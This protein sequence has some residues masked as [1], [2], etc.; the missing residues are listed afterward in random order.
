MPTASGF[1]L[2]NYVTTINW[3]K[4]KLFHK[5]RRAADANE[6]WKKSS[7]PLQKSKIN[8]LENKNK[9]FNTN[10]N[11]L[12]EN[13]SILSASSKLSVKSMKNYVEL[14]KKPHFGNIDDAESEKNYANPNLLKHSE[15]SIS[16][17]TIDPADGKKDL[18]EN[19]KLQ[20]QK[21]NVNKAMPVTKT[22]KVLKTQSLKNPK[23]NLKKEPLRKNKI[24]ESFQSKDADM[25]ALNK[26]NYVNTKN[27]KNKNFLTN[28]D[29][30]EI[31]YDNESI[32]LNNNIISE[33]RDRNSMWT[34]MKANGVDKENAKKN[35]VAKNFNTNVKSMTKGLKQFKNN[36]LDKKL[37]KTNIVLEIK[38]TKD[39]P[40]ETIDQIQFIKNLRSNSIQSLYNLHSIRDNTEFNFANRS[41][42]DDPSLINHLDS[43]F[44]NVNRRPLHTKNNLK[45]NI[46]V[47]T[48]R[49]YLF[50]NSKETKQLI[51]DQKSLAHDS[52]DSLVFTETSSLSDN[53]NDKIKEKSSR[54]KKIAKKKKQEIFDRTKTPSSESSDDSADGDHLKID[55]K[56]DLKFFIKP[57]QVNTVKET[58]EN[59]EDDEIDEDKLRELVS[60]LIKSKKKKENPNLPPAVAKTQVKN[61]KTVKTEQT[62]GDKGYTIYLDKSGTGGGLGDNALP[63]IS[64]LLNQSK[65]INQ[66]M[67]STFY[68][69]DD[70]ELNY[71]NNLKN[72]NNINNLSN[73]GYNKN[74]GFIENNRNNQIKNKNQNIPLNNYGNNR[75][76]VQS[77]QTI[78]IPVNESLKTTVN[79]GW[80]QTSFADYSQRNNN[81]TFQQRHNIAEQSKYKTNNNFNDI[82][83]NRVIIDETRLIKNS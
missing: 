2:G 51:S 15:L 22:K 75:V 14:K 3:G 78:P 81:E 57:R 37:D 53:E 10:I 43:N 38:S 83:N 12:N 1:G 23:E 31:E 34:N 62:T 33:R 49:N 80:N 72:V 25:E 17:E 27:I 65:N 47:K 70:S 48:Q 52:D 40:V 18:K 39:H 29:A 6:T 68:T 11:D 32:Q 44:V 30:L 54:N 45:E 28:F 77:N 16:S 13:E 56:G 9:N 61:K 82:F 69:A 46:G 67:A 20:A 35:S 79:E 24:R 5:R 66:N 55:Q 60:K 64:S 41:Y 63:N 73:R 4:S 8:N 59:I 50:T 26:V 7:N 21:K 36:S 19:D 76:D 74:N 58:T 42:I 71:T